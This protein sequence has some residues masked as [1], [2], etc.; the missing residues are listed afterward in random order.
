GHG[1][2][3]TRAELRL[4]EP[5]PEDE[6]LQEEFEIHVENLKNEAMKQFDQEL[7]GECLGTFR[8]LCELE[9]ENRTLRDYLQLCWQFVPEAKEKAYADQQAKALTDGNGNTILSPANVSSTALPSEE[10]GLT[11]GNSSRSCEAIQGREALRPAGPGRSRME[12]ELCIS[13]ELN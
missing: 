5:S 7:Y 2:V 10:P 12:S 9:P 8:F 3:E 6:K 13:D 4:A 11:G 1:H